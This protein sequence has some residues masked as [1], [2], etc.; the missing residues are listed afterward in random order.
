MHPVLVNPSL[1]RHLETKYA[2]VSSE[3]AHTRSRLY[4]ASGA[5][6]EEIAGGYAVFTE[7]GCPVSGARG[8]GMKGAVS[9]AAMDNLE[10]FFSDRGLIPDLMLC[11][12]VDPSLLHLLAGRGYGIS[13]FDNV[14]LRSLNRVPSPI[15]PNP[16]VEITVALPDQA[17]LWAETV[18]LGFADGGPVSDSSRRIFVTQFHIPKTICYLA[19]V[20]DEIAGGAMLNLLGDIA[21]LSTTSTLPAY[22]G[23]RVQ[24]VLIEARLHAAAKA[25]F[26]LATVMARPG[27]SSERNL[28]RAG[29]QLAYTAVRMKKRMEWL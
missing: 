27:S 21:T 12:L 11:P 15:Q 6:V 1:A 5:C 17:D 20:N 4:P 9:E 3:H 8:L 2:L 25:G 18:A 19:R 14:Y 26:E 10:R 24:T 22:R 29:F 16:T 13:E 23:M 7:P 28:V